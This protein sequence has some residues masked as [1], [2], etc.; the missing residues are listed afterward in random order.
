MGMKSWRANR[1]RD[2]LEE[3][4]AAMLK[5]ESGRQLQNLR[6]GP[7]RDE[8]ADEWQEGMAMKRAD[9]LGWRSPASAS[10]VDG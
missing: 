10:P 6:Y 9:I 5:T 1:T 4:L 8:R 7:H 3:A 2:L